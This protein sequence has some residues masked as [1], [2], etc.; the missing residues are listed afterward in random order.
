[1]Q[2]T[3]DSRVPKGSWV[4]AGGLPLIFT[5]TRLVREKKLDIFVEGA[6]ASVKHDTPFNIS[7]NFS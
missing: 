7:I 3:D 2:D 4:E 5:D 6:S 1:M